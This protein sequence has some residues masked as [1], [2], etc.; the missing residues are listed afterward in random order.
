MIETVV[1]IEEIMIDCMGYRIKRICQTKLKHKS[2]WECCGTLHGGW[3][4]PLDERNSSL[5]S[6]HWTFIDSTID[7]RYSRQP[8]LEVK[9]IHKVT[10]LW[11]PEAS[12]SRVRSESWVLTDS[13]IDARYTR[14]QNLE[15]KYNQKVAKV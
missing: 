7:A 14:S 5:H 10:Q 8:T 4:R 2:G 13:T 6:G 3:L 11:K 15:V 9:H 12:K 1:E